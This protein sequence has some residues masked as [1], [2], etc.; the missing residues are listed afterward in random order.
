MK[1]VRRVGSAAPLHRSPLFCACF[2]ISLAGF[3]AI[4]LY[5]VL[6]PQSSGH[7]SAI[8][9]RPRNSSSISQSFIN[10]LPALF[11]PEFGKYYSL[12]REFLSKL[13]QLASHAPS[14]S[15]S[16]HRQLIFTVF[17]SN[18]LFLAE[19][20]FC[21]SVA[22]GVGPDLHIFIALDRESFSEMKSFNREVI[23]FDVSKRGF[24][25]EQFCKI[26]LVIQ[27]HLL[28]MN[29][30]ATICDDDAVFLKNPVALFGN[31]ADFEVAAESNDRYFSETFNFDI[32][33]VGF[34][35]VIPSQ[36]SILMYHKW[37]TLAIPDSLRLDQNVLSGLL[38]A[39]RIRGTFEANQLFDVTR[40]LKCKE[41]LKVRWFDPLEVTN[42]KVYHLEHEVTRPVARARGIGKPFIVHLSWIP[43]AE[44][45]QVLTKWKLWFIKHGKCIAGKTVPDRWT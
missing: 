4:P 22:S 14:N 37:L 27:Y 11:P 7:T 38:L 3:L 32:M 5:L 10:R 18:H 19:N 36:I 9:K 16:G 44:K 33:N 39:V 34:L 43:P 1:G 6:F 29:V 31:W 15:H 40:L 23:L 45:N 21:S 25:Y 35:R 30:E 2:L 41:I 24:Q 12:P 13:D 20:L 28:L 42:G 8:S 17:D 26:K